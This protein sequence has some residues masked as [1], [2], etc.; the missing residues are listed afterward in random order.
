MLNPV[1]SI[2]VREWAPS[3]FLYWEREC[4]LEPYRAKSCDSAR[5]KPTAR[6]VTQRQ[7]GMSKKYFCKIY[8]IYY[9]IN[10]YACILSDIYVTL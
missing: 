3:F 1:D 7:N 2:S 6:H 4:R 10:V 8:Y 9:A 5:W